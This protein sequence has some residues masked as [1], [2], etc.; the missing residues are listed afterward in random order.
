MVNDYVRELKKYQYTST[1][2]FIRT[3]VVSLKSKGGFSKT[4]FITFT[5]LLSKTAI[6]KPS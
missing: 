4:D 2:I 1:T 6:I 5:C 3:V